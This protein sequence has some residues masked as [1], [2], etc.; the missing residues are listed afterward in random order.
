LKIKFMQELITNISEN[1]E[2]DNR[3]KSRTI[4]DYEEYICQKC[5]EMFGSYEDYNEHFDVNCDD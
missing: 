3:I 4:E 2:P 5:G 1:K